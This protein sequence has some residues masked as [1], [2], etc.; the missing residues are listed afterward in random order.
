MCLG[1]DGRDEFGFQ[2][3]LEA[4]HTHFAADPGLLVATEGR[5]R[6]VPDAAVDVDGA[7]PQPRR[8]RL[9]AVVVA[10]EHRARQAVRGII[11]DAYRVVV[12]VVGD[13]RQYRAEDLLARYLR[14]VVQS[15][16]DGRFDEETGVQVGRAPAA[17]GE[18][19]ALGDRGVQITLD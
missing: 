6:R 14:R 18:A 12:A 2:V 17:A 9:G 5:V 16:N 8:H 7:D 10:A 11:G 19:A 1:R 4:G 15:G 3:F 13:H